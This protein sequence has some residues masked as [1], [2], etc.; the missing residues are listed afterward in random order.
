MPSAGRSAG[1][2]FAYTLGQRKSDAP[3]WELYEVP[4]N[5]ARRF[6]QKLQNPTAAFPANVTPYV[7]YEALARMLERPTLVQLTGGVVGEL[8]ELSDEV[9]GPFKNVRKDSQN[10]TQLQQI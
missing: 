7:G 3:I 5:C 10:I 2:D 8:T 6:G 4:N 9:L 1:H